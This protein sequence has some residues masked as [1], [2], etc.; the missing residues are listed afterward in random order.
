M[1]LMNDNQY[2]SEGRFGELLLLIPTLQ[3]VA[4]LLVMKIAA[5]RRDGLHVDELLCDILLGEEIRVPL[6]LP[7]LDAANMQL[8][9]P[10]GENTDPTDCSAMGF[11]GEVRQDL[12]PAD[13]RSVDG[14]QFSVHQQLISC[15]DRSDVNGGLDVGHGNSWIYD[16]MSLSAEAH[17]YKQPPPVY[18]RKMEDELPC[19]ALQK[20]LIGPFQ[21]QAIEEN[22]MPSQSDS[23]IEMNN[24]HNP[25]LACSPLPNYSAKKKTG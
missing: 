17:S 24:G 15:T 16:N 23:F 10:F 12:E 1:N 25:G 7:T 19:D 2:L 11:R 14:G 20:D 13:W 4:K 8:Q 18:V 3:R 21:G 5:A 9:G 22:K 6:M